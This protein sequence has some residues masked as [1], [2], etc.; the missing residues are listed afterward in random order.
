MNMQNTELIKKYT[1]PNTWHPG[2]DTIIY[3]LVTIYLFI[4]LGKIIERL[5]CIGTVSTCREYR[6]VKVC[7]L[8]KHDLVQETEKNCKST[9]W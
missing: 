1:S 2:D 7:V 6:Y 4:H 9:E 5:P 3:Q 8:E